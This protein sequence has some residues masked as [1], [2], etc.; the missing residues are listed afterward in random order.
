MDR[1]NTQIQKEQIPKTCEFF[2]FDDLNKKLFCKFF[3]IELR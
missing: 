1:C 2:R 3:F